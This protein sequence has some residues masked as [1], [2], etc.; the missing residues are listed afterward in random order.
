MRKDPGK[1]FTANEIYQGLGYRYGTDFWGFIGGVAA[2]WT[3][4]NALETP[5]KEGS[6]KAKIVK[7][8]F[9]E[10]TYYVVT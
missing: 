8:R 2:L 10:D 6:V 7:Q 3:I 5:V 9:G 4:Q 1:G